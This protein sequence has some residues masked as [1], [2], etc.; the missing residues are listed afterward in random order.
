[1]VDSL[2]RRPSFY[3]MTNISV[4]WKAHLLVQYSKNSFACELMDG[5]VLYD[6]FNIVDDIIYYKR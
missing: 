4:D 1:V 6:N 3:A 2:S 5:K